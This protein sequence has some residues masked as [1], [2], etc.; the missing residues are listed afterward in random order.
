MQGQNILQK[1]RSTY[2]EN[3]S[4]DKS[5]GRYYDCYVSKYL[6]V[7]LKTKKSTCFRGSQR[8]AGGGIAVTDNSW[9]GL[10]KVGRNKPVCA[11]GMV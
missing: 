1:R 6:Y 3:F 4:L 7:K 8:A 10:G 5:V 9:N 11:G 2:S